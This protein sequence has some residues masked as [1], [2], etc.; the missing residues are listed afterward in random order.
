MIRVPSLFAL[1]LLMSCSSGA[2]APTEVQ[3]FA[4]RFPPPTIHVTD[5]SEGRLALI[6]ALEFVKRDE[7]DV[8]LVVHP[9]IDRRVRMQLARVRPVI[10]PARVPAARGIQF[11]AGYLILEELTVTADSAYFRGWAG[12]PIPEGTGL[13]C[14]KGYEFPLHRTNSGDYLITNFTFRVC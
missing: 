12:G 10:A 4:Q 3:F 2:P 9:S 1:A 5:W 8:I 6:A 7:G 14:G 13:S 11:P